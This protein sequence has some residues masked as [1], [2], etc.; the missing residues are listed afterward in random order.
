[1]ID[2]DGTALLS[3]IPIRII[4]KMFAT[5]SRRSPM[6][7][8]NFYLQFVCK[9]FSVCL[10]FGDYLK[11]IFDFLFIILNVCEIF[12]IGKWRNGMC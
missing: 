7:R 5:C 10:I 8:A 2:V 11:S 1:M 6:L 3:E 9:R 4:C 12:R